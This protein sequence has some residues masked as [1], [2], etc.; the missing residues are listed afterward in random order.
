MRED[1]AS[2]DD[3][4]EEMSER[5]KKLFPQIQGRTSGSLAAAGGGN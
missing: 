3:V 5:F 2:K 1:M 4:I